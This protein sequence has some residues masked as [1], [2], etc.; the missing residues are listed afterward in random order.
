MSKNRLEAFS[1]GVIAIIITIMVLGLKTP[2]TSDWSGIAQQ[3]PIFLGYLLS[4]VFVGIYWGNHHHLLHIVHR[5]SA[6]IMWANMNL[7]FWLSLIPFATD[8]MGQ[9]HFSQNSVILY[10]CLLMVCGASYSILQKAIKIH[11]K[12]DPRMERM[13]RGQERKGIYSLVLY[14]LSI[15]FAFWNT[16]VS[17]MLFVVVAT[18]WIVPDRNIERVIYES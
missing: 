5:V 6:S 11:H 14:S 9:T 4:F 7:L 1:D 16:A 18:M 12:T 2:V 8:W 17:G 10:A 13:L 15:L 3:I